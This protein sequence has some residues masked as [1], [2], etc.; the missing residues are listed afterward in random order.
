[1]KVAIHNSPNSFSDRWISYCEKNKIDY[2]IVN[3]YDSD[4]ISQLSDCDAFM[5]HHAHYD[6][7]DCLF[8]KQLIFALNLIGKKTVPSV[9]SD[10]HF[11]DKLTQKYA[12]EAIGAPVIKSYVFYDA[13]SAMQWV[14]TASFPKVFKTRCGAGS[15]NVR[16]V[17]DKRDAKK[18]I[19]QAFSTKGF[20]NQDYLNLAKMSFIKICGGKNDLYNFCRNA[21]LTVFPS[22]CRDKR[23]LMHN[24]KGYVY[25]QD[26]IKN[27]GYD[28]RVVVVGDRAFAIKRL[29]RENDFRAS[30]S[31]RILFDKKYFD[32]KVIRL[33][34][35][36]SKKLKADLINFDF[37]IDA[38]GNPHICEMNYGFAK[39]GY[40][41]CEGYWD[42]DLIWHEGSNFDFCGWMVE[43]LRK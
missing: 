14:E 24:E 13:K 10:W 8:A 30:G 34:F 9:Y 31:G 22:L 32:E 36:L 21:I 25:F 12:L 4:I 43:L 17:K 2:K 27:D 19:K 11:D 20:P 5:W 3:A 39:T 33:S 41:K 1:M 18:L 40:D 37:I 35:D 16:L 38:D 23:N 7:R 29:C 6:Y 15:S 42:S 26:F 28:I